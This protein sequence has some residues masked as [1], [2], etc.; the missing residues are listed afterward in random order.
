MFFHLSLPR[1]GCSLWLPWYKRCVIAK[2]FLDLNLA[3]TKESTE[4]FA[5]TIKAFTELRRRNV[6]HISISLKQVHIT[7]TSRFFSLLPDTWVDELANRWLCAAV[8]VC[9][10]AIAARCGSHNRREMGW[11]S[12]ELSA[13]LATVDKGRG[14]SHSKGG[15]SCLDVQCFS[16]LAWHAYT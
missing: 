4:E 7:R 12:R 14:S 3:F 15:Y 9:A 16:G 13:W 11:L 10:P 1:D 5:D 6:Q 8:H 2:G